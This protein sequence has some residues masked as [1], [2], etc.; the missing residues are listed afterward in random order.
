MSLEVEGLNEWSCRSCWLGGR[1]RDRLTWCVCV[2]VCVGAHTDL[3]EESSVLAAAA[4]T[5]AHV[6]R[7]DS[8]SLTYLG[9]NH[10]QQTIC[11]HEKRNTRVLD[12][13]NRW[14]SSCC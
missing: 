5:V 1:M 12:D 13:T 14:G 7:I 10:R 9:V 4:E 6:R 2:C 3:P 8:H 11:K